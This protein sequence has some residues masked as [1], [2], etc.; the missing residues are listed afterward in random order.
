MAVTQDKSSKYW[1][2]AVQELREHLLK[3]PDSQLDAA[4]KPM[5]EKWDDEPTPIQILEVL[6]LVIH[7]ALGSDFMVSVLQAIY[8][9]QCKKFNTTH[10]DVVK[11]ATWREPPPPPPPVEER[12]DPSAGLFTVQCDG[13]KAIFPAE[14]RKCSCG[15]TKG[16]LKLDVDKMLNRIYDKHA[17]GKEA[18][19]I[20]VIFDVFWNLHTKWDFMNEILTK[21]DVSKLDGS[22]LVGFMV[23]TFKYIKQVPAHLDFCDRAAARM[24]EMGYD[25]KR[26]HDL[27]D[28]YRETGDYWKNMAGVPTWLSGPRPE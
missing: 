11:Q 4:V 3:A 10:E 18:G 8:D 26:I 1:R 16:E 15:A 21:A 12:D 2:R 9:V 24:K 6:D 22:L 27:V 17:Q 28:R 19:A 25:D 5:I 13:C 23:Q 7:D 14:N 20:D